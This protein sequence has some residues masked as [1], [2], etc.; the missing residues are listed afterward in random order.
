MS[1][2]EKADHNITLTKND[3]AVVFNS[4]GSMNV[5]VPSR[6]E[7]EP[8]PPQML[9]AILVQEMLKDAFM[10]K[11]LTDRVVAAGILG[12]QTPEESANA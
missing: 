9:Y 1:D 10:L 4:D 11:V 7:G 12:T 3:C 2:V 8:V 6:E 5:F